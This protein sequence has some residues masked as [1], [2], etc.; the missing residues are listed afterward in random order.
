MYC[1]YLLYSKRRSSYSSILVVSCTENHA[2]MN[3]RTDWNAKSGLVA[4][5][6]WRRAEGPPPQS[7]ESSM[8][9]PSPPLP[10]PLPP[11]PPPLT[12]P[13]RAASTPSAP[14]PASP[15]PPAASPM[16]STIERRL[17]RSR[18]G[19]RRCARQC[20]TTWVARARFSGFT[21]GACHSR[22]SANQ[23]KEVH[24]TSAS[25][26][27]TRSFAAAYSAIADVHSRFES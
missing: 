26:W 24:V 10:P 18:K 11:E 9:S 17:R 16:L 14:P 23:Q 21:G 22:A 6:H 7:S 27:N 13:A 5:S 20:R 12:P 4:N 19:S 8:S 25:G 15:P 1:D 3:R 2:S